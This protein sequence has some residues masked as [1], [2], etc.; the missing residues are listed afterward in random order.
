MAGV[1]VW[2]P[3]LILE[4]LILAGEQFSK[5][6]LKLAYLLTQDSKI[7]YTEVF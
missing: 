6:I 4:S 7:W 2:P 3:K 1:V 5:N